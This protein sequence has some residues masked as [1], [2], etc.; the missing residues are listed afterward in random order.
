MTRPQIL[1]LSVSGM[2]V[3]L[4]LLVLFS[5][6][7]SAPSTAHA[8][9]ILSGRNV[10]VSSTTPDNTYVAAGQVNVD[11]PSLADLCA[12]GGTITVSAPVGRDA[13]LV[14][15]TIDLRKPVA[16]NARVVGGRVTVDDTVGGD[17]MAAGGF[18]TVTGKAKN[19]IIGGGTVDVTNGS[20]GPVTIYGADVTLAGQFNGDVEVVASDKVTV[21][22]GT[23]IHGAFKYNAPQQADIP[24]SAHVDGEVNYIGS[25][26]YLPTTQQAKTFALAGLWVFFLVQLAA[27]IVAAGLIT[28]LFPAF[29]DRVVE[30]TLT[31]SV[32]RFILLALLGFAGFVAVPVLIVLLVVSFVGIGLAIIGIA[33]Y[34]LFLLVSYIYAAAL[35]GSLL[36]YAFRRRKNISSW[37]ISWRG[38][39]LGMIALYLIGTL[40]FIGL[41][42]RVVLSAA[43]GGAVLSILYR[44][45]FRRDSHETGDFD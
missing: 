2:L 1:A 5:G 3:T 6:S 4:P 30:L 31:R 24:L 40:P 9:T 34:A 42:V 23:V 25:A 41:I 38:A 37:Q 14:G 27:A 29:T 44:F 35:T 32:E 28:G 11:T 21:S 10:T 26:P 15:G 33:A 16:G 36:L 12:A 18:V 20:N 8:A 13:L 22:E 43:A 39:V 17:L 7:F 45:A 19:T